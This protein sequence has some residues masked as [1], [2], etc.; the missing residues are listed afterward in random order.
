MASAL[1]LEGL[2]TGRDRVRRLMRLMGISAVVP[3]P[4]SVKASSHWRG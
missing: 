3:R 1:R 2:G 4:T